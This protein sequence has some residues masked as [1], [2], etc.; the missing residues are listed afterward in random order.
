M[1]NSSKQIER[2][3]IS[4]AQ[5][6]SEL[7]KLFAKGITQK[8]NAYEQTRTKFKMEKQRFWKMFDVVH[9][10]WA[11]LKDK[12][13]S[14]GIS[15][16]TK[17]AVKTGLKSKLEKQLHIQNQIDAIQAD[18]DRGVLEEYTY[19]HG[20]YEVVEKI[21]NA[22]TKAYLRKT[23]KDL[24]AELNKMEGDYAPTKVD[25]NH[26]GSVQIIKLPDNGRG[27]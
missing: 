26:T 2:K 24:Y 6:R 19:I 8:S 25:N 20:E 27:N 22:E 21:M 14:E 23:M 7:R 16:A 1:G 12:A 15:E 11:N 9:S 5:L 17:E 4:D 10:D 3:S 13:E 18:I